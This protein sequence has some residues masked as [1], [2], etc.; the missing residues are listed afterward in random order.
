LGEA[1]FLG[2]TGPVVGRRV[3]PGLVSSA[4]PIYEPV[5]PAGP[6]VDSMTQADVQAMM[7]N[8]K[9]VQSGARAVL[10]GATGTCA[11]V[12]LRVDGTLARIPTACAGLVPLRA[13]GSGVR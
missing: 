10:Q 13:W 11:H 8:P 12:G 1:G 7:K 5:T 3:Q 9:Y 6:L 2:V 4:P